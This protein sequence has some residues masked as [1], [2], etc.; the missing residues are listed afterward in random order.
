MV[1]TCVRTTNITLSQKRLEI[2]VHVYVPWYTCTN[3]GSIIWCVPMVPIGLPYRTRSTMVP[4]GTM[5]LEYHGTNGT[6][7][8]MP[9]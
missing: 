8:G 4:Y 5:V 1:R 7:G 3:N 9:Y 2:Q 6:S